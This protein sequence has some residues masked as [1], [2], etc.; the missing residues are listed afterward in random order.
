[1]DR[2]GADDNPHIPET[3]LGGKGFLT[4]VERENWQSVGSQLR[5]RVGLKPQ[6]M[7]MLYVPPLAPPARP[8]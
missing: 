4:I 6:A 7:A 2:R 5:T 3:R 8:S 1:M